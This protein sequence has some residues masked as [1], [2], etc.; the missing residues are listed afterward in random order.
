M[1]DV[2]IIRRLDYNP[3]V[4][5]R[6]MDSVASKKANINV[7]QGVDGHIGWSR[8]KGYAVG[9]A[10]F[11][12]YVDDDDMV[13]PGLLD[14]LSSALEEHPDMS[15]LHVKC[16]AV[17]RHAPIRPPLQNLDLRIT[18]IKQGGHITDHLAV[19]RRDRLA[20]LLNMYTQYPR[21]GDNAVLSEYISG[22]TGD[23]KVGIVPAQHYFWC[24]KD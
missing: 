7:V 20:P 23:D 11:V 17:S 12:T 1:L 15:F 18:H 4:L 22:V 9:N 14:A 3:K 2:H 19:F 8:I 24:G 21:G 6:C 16:R 10:P 13:T 5:R